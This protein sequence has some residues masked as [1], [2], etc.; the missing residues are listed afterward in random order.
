MHEWAL[1]QAVVYT[2]IEYQRKEKLKE[3]VELEIKIGELQ[4]IDR[5]IF[6]FALKEIVQLKK[7]TG[8]RV[9][10]EKEEAILKCRVCGYQWSF[11]DSMKRLSGEQAEFIHF[12]PE[13]IHIHSRCPQCKS[14][15]FEI[16]KGRGVKIT[17]IKGIK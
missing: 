7:M 4:Q 2:A 1:A 13:V 15:D 9:R 3:I 6:E 16:V 17:A 5:E 10:V 14:P 12:L 8:M 11:A